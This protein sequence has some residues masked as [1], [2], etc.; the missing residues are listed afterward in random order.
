[1]VVFAVIASICGFVYMQNQLE[2][3]AFSHG[4]W[5]W[6]SWPVAAV[7]V[8]LFLVG[9]L[10]GYWVISVVMVFGALGIVGYNQ[11]MEDYLSQEHRFPDDKR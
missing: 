6:L 8:G 10:T 5:M 3:F 4:I 7:W 9:A 2:D 11:Q 1:M